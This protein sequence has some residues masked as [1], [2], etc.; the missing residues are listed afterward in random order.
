MLVPIVLNAC[1][2]FMKIT[3][4]YTPRIGDS[5]GK[6]CWFLPCGKQAVYIYDCIVSDNLP[7]SFKIGIGMAS[8]TVLQF[9]SFNIDYAC[10]IQAPIIGI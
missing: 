4:S 2:Q 6:S 10:D 9:W 3:R 1:K 8:V 7:V 5:Q